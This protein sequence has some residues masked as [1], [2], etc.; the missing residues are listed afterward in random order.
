MKSIKHCLNKQLA[1][2]CR[3]SVQLE[4]L[5]QK[6]NS[7]L[8]S[9]LAPYCKVSSFNKGCLI[10]VATDATWASQLRYAIP[11]LRDQLRKAGMY[12]L[13][14]IKVTIADTQE[15][16]KKSKSI[17]YELTHQTKERIVS[18]SQHCTYEPLRQ[19][20]LHLAQGDD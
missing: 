20:L 13:S 8:P 2:I 5:T 6:I 3:R 1:E 15:Y 9:D 17:H 19:A 7:L 16:K 10:L 11:E 12:Q 14:S 4:E 18:E